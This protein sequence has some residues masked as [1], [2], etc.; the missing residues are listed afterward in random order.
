[1]EISAENKS[2]DI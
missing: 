1:V 2:Q